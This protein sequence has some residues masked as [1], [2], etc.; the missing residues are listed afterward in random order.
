MIPLRLLYGPALLLVWQ[1]VPAGVQRDSAGRLYLAL[2]AEVGRVEARQLNCQGDVVSAAQ[3]PYGGGGGSI[4][5]W[6]SAR[7]R[8]SGAAGGL[9]VNRLEARAFGTV[10]AAYEGDKVGVGGGVGYLA[11]PEIP[12]PPAAHPDSYPNPHADGKQYVV[13]AIYLRLGRR[14][15]LHVQAELLPPTETPTAT[16]YIRFGIGDASIGASHLGI[17]TGV[18][19][20]PYSN[21]KHEFRWFGDFSVPVEDR[22]DLGLRLLL[23]SGEFN[24]TTGL[25]VVARYR[26]DAR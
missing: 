17:L 23:G 22:F 19:A 12:L 2:G 24:P 11:Y 5:Y 25:G 3:V 26:F 4:E 13:P 21:G 1:T 15:D 7:L 20:G 18:T 9:A 14:T 6:P 10:M 8:L 16:G